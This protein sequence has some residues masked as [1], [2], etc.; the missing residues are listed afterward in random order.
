MDISGLETRVLGPA[1]LADYHAHLRRL[2]RTSRRSRFAAT[3]DDL[4]IDCHC[5]QLAA[6]D[7]IIIGAFTG[8]AM[9]GGA[10]IVPAGP[11]RAEAAFTVEE[12]YQAH[13]IGGVL[14]DNAIRAAREAGVRELLFEVLADNSA[15]IELIRRNGGCVTDRGPMLSLRIALADTAL[16]AA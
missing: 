7:A 12:A 5:L 15:M 3:V 10:E 16:S 9:R 1:G 4:S 14:L 11:G 8:G 13:G 2:D 6:Q